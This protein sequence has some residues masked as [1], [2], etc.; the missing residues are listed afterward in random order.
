MVAEL[1]PLTTSQ[2]MAVTKS[3][4][5]VTGQGSEVR[6]QEKEFGVSSSEWLSAEE[7]HRI[8]VHEHNEVQSRFLPSPRM[9]SINAYLRWMCNTSRH[10]TGI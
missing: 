3:A 9:K 2:I 10:I 6:A 1:Y 8:F 5:L 4:D 7:L